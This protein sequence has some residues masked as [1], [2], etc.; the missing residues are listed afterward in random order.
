[1]EL[2]L[3]LQDEANVRANKHLHHLGQRPEVLKPWA[4]ERIVRLVSQES[5]EGGAVWTISTSLNT[6]HGSSPSP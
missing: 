3:L 1:M 5:Q 6:T 2:G 4:Q